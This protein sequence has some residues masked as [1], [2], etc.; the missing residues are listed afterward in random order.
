VEPYVAAFEVG[1]R[2]VIADQRELETF[3]R[4]WRY[5]N[6][7]QTKQLAS[8]R[9]A[10]IM[11]AIPSTSW[12]EFRVSGTRSVCVEPERETA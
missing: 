8:R 1:S 4:T 6:K 2:V 10:S 11:E 5:H 3:T 9:W 7:L 12:R